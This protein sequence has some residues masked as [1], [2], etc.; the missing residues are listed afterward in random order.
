[1]NR[2]LRISAFLLLGLS[3]GFSRPAHATHAQGGDLTY[4]SLG[5]NQYRVVV[6]HFRDC[7]G[8]PAPTTLQLNCNPSG[9]SSTVGQVTAVMSRQGATL[10]GNQYCATLTGICTTNGP[11]NYETNTFV[12]TVTLPPAATWVLSTE[13]CCRPST[14]NLVGQASFRFEAVLHNQIIAGGAVQNIVN[15]SPAS[16]NL[17]VFFIP[18]KQTSI[19]S[20]SAFDADGDSLVYSL[21]RPLESCGVYTD[22]SPYPTSTCVPAVLSVTPP[23]VLS[24]PTSLPTTYL[25]T[26][27]VAVTNDTIGLCPNKTVTPRFNFDSNSGAL[28]VEPAYFDSVSASAAGKNKYVVVVKITEY[29]KIGG[30]YVVVGTARRDLFLTVYNCGTN[31][32]PTFLRTA[33]MQV[34]T[35]TITQSLN[36]VIPIR[37]GEPAILNLTATD[38]NPNQT[39]NIALDYN[40]VPG[41][42]LRATGAGLARLTFT[43]PLSMRDG[44]Y[45]VAITAEDNA[46]PLKG[47]ETQTIAFRVFGSPLATRTAAAPAIAAY[48]NPFTSQVQ[49]QLAKA[50]VQ[51]L[52]ICDQ[53]G[54]VVGQVQSQADGLVRWQPG[55]EV[56][57]GLYL[58]RT[59]DGNQTVRLLRSEMK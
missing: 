53:L 52:T 38:R 57:A 35:S 14:A 22:Y 8:I 58:A 19:L 32:P 4:T 13:E 31:F 50:G 55:A 36:T 17:P 42:T 56:P 49:F 11:A 2:F 37:S 54:R 12:A 47:S 10:F 39:L 3:L 18:W 43:P 30:S 5:N 40:T 33:T 45:R 25:A 41:A 51:Q 23:C 6:H 21:D 7:S 15:T 24:C 48:P 16:S 34:G 9:C 29:R 1:M 26:L 20:N 46:C 27:P 28:R 44:L 59:A